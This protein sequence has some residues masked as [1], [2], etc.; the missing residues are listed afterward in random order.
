MSAEPR[1]STDPDG[2]LDDFCAHSVSMVHFEAIDQS[3]WYATVILNDGSYW[4]LNFGAVNPTAKGYAR[5]EQ[6][7]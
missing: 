2:T 7:K 6:V 1:I 5:A 4:Q 3:R